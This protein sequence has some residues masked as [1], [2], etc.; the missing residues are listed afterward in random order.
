VRAS[1]LTIALLA[2]SPAFALGQALS[3]DEAL[4]G[5]ADA[6]KQS[7]AVAAEPADAPAAGSPAGAEAAKSPALAPGNAEQTDRPAVKTLLAAGGNGR[8]SDA[9]AD[10]IAK[11]LAKIRADAASRRG[12]EVAALLAAC[13]TDGDG[14]VSLPEARIAVAQA[15][16]AVD[17]RASVADRVI[18]AIDKDGDGRADETELAAYLASLGTVRAVVEPLA[19]RLWNSAD[20][21]RDHGV[22][23]MEARLAAD[24]FGRLQLYSGDGVISGA[25]GQ[26]VVDPTAWM[27][28][29]RVIERADADGSNALS[30]PEVAGTTVFKAQFAGLDRDR[31]GEV[32]AAELY[33]MASDLS[34][35]A[36]SQTC[37][38]C[39]L[40]KKSG[41]EKLELL[42]SLLTLR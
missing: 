2:G 6:L 34:K 36:Q 16:P 33:A 38:T 42:Q 12:G 25:A 9:Q 13:D 18:G 4:V 14:R 27:Q 28:V 24:Q 7:K 37:A 22:D 3:L 26:G 31:S 39:P 29:V 10:A 32:T 5:A 8:V 41:A 40:V 20:T 1:L 19:V 17:P 23:V 11:R 21:N 15:R 35:T 30:A